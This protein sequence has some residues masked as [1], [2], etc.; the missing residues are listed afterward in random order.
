[1][2]DFD[3]YVQ[4]EGSTIKKVVA[5]EVHP[6]KHCGITAVTS[7][8]DDDNWTG[9]HLAQANLYGYGR[10]IWNPELSSEQIVEE[11][12]TLTFGQDKDVQNTIQEFLL[13]SWSIYESYTSPL[14]VGWMVK[15]HYHYG[16]DIDGYEYSK[17][18]TYHFADFKGIGVDRT[19]ATGTG[20]TAQYEKPN[21]ELYEHLDTCPDELL[22]FFHHV[23]YTHRLH[24]G[25]TVIQHI[26]D[27]HF[28]GVERV[29]YWIERWKQLQSKID[30]ARYTHVLGRLEEQ[31]ENAIQWRDIVNT[32]FFRKSGIADEQGRKIY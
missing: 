8:G 27:T 6:Y 20:Y 1:M 30:N 25:K 13:E 5:G 29:Q 28:E 22:L 11:W 2:L 24:S 3:T 17:W 32:Y 21:A 19:V 26:Y 9:H 18:G 23:S 14:G 31:L 15:P 16:P 10:L 12:T 4:G 7:I